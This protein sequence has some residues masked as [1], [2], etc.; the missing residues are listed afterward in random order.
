MLKRP[1]RLRL[2]A[3]LTL[4][5]FALVVLPHMD[6]DDLAK[7]HL[8]AFGQICFC[9]V[10]PDGQNGANHHPTP[11]DHCQNCSSLHSFILNLVGISSEPPTPVL[12]IVEPDDSVLQDYI[13]FIFRPPRLA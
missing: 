12:N 10:A 5:A 13:G 1:T 11:A 7:S 3:A 9:K 2:F 6:V 4:G 8:G